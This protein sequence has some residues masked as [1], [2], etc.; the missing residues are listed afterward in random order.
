VVGEP[1]PVAEQRAVR[2]RARR[3][4]RDHADGP[5]VRAHVPDE[6]RDQARLADAGRAGDAD[7]VRAAGLR[8]ELGNELVRDGVGVLDQRDRA[9]ERAP[10]AGAH[11]LGERLAR[12][13]SP[14]GH[15]GDCSAGRG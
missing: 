14:S 13:L 2:E 4:D 3:V 12:P 6:C 8:V 1:D 7:G 15:G 5:V 11:A 9:R 10:V